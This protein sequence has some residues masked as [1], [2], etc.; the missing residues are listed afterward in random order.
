MDDT[1]FRAAA[2]ILVMFTCTAATIF[3]ARTY[4]DISQD[5]VSGA[6]LSMRGSIWALPLT[7]VIFT[8]AA[9]MG[10]PQWLL[11]AAAVLA[12][13]PVHGGVY[14]WIATMISASFDFW[15]ARRI[16][17]KR[18]EDLSGAF[19]ARIITLV[20]R[21]G[22]LTSFAVRLVPTGPFILV[23]MAAGV[24][25]LSFAAFISGTALG[26]IPKILVVALLGQGALTAAQGETFMFAAIIGAVLIIG[27]MLV[28]RQVLRPV[29]MVK[30][31]SS[32]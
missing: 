26:I 3:I 12:F 24:S 28:G 2:I 5:D 22:F 18:I 30:E 16:G 13:G 1:A 27:L 15:L 32:E 23:N 4:F 20:R 6:M 21:N 10:M 29:L 7:I 11:I 25:G 14:A 9:F 17:A 19:L 31:K 8:A